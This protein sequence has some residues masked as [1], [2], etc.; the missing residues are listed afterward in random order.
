MPLNI[1]NGNFGFCEFSRLMIQEFGEQY[2]C[3]NPTEEEKK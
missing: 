2:L 1:G 3:Q